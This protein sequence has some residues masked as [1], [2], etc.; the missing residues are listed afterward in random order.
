MKAG[1]TR[2]FPTAA[3]GR[4][5]SAGVKL[6]NGR[7]PL[8][9]RA[10]LADSDLA[11]KIRLVGDPKIIQQ[12]GL[13]GATINLSAISAQNFRDQLDLKGGGE[14]LTG[15]LTE[16][17]RVYG[18]TSQLPVILARLGVTRPQVEQLLAE[19]LMRTMAGSA[20]ATLSM[21][22][23][24]EA[25]AYIYSLTNDFIILA[26]ASEADDHDHVNFII[27]IMLKAIQL[28]DPGTAVHSGVVTFYAAKIA[29]A[30]GIPV[31]GKLFQRIKT[32][33]LLHD[34]GK[35]GIPAATL[36]LPRPNK[37]EIVLLNEH[38]SVSIYFLSGI[39]WLKNIIPPVQHHHD[40][41]KDYPAWAREGVLTPEQQLAIQIIMVA[42]RFDGMTS[43]RLHKSE[44]EYSLRRGGI[45]QRQKVFS[46]KE[47]I[48][49]IRSE[50][51]DL[52]VL[53]A[54]EEVLQSGARRLIDLKE[55][56][57]LDELTMVWYGIEHLIK[58]SILP[59]GPEERQMSLTDR[60]LR[61]KRALLWLISGRPVEP[62]G[63]TDLIRAVRQAV[64]QKI[65]EEKLG[66][67]FSAIMG[68]DLSPMMTLLLFRALRADE[69]LGGDSFLKLAQVFMFYGRNEDKQ[70]SVIKKL[71][72]DDEEHM[73]EFL[74]WVSTALYGESTLDLPVAGERAFAE[75][76][77]AFYETAIKEGLT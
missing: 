45:E 28:H 60:Y 53:E 36:K 15:W 37:D 64:E 40:I 46:K 1:E 58:K 16:K 72:L 35:L 62:L 9:T 61:A 48:D 14:N 22:D 10:Q 67:K 13:P 8:L 70:I 50:G 75:Q 23:E 31:D 49:Q 69:L 27:N 54:L 12:F 24:F 5:M 30:L 55:H 6:T 44:G 59:I 77:K 19:E 21:P 26:N 74:D 3:F 18:G 38:L 43:D 34:I 4:L 42:D 73:P 33:S 71:T 7:R 65:F 76:V 52:A 29:A 63:A 20:I 68:T 11:Q 57:R 41:K 66:Q 2:I 56:F 17:L 39:M 51:C 25:A 32:A 47:A